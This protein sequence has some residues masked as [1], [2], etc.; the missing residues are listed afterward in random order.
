[1]VD[2]ETASGEPGVR[3]P[4]YGKLR[5]LELPR[6][7]NV[8]GPG[9]VQ[10]NFDSDS[11]ASQV[12]NLLSQQGSQVIKG[13][14]LTLPVGGGLLYVQPVYVQSSSGTQYPLLR[15]VLVSFGDKVGFADTLSEA[16][17]QVFGG[18]SGA[19]TGEDVVDGDAAAANN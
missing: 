2:S 17:D 1:A 3:N 13:N 16:L 9:Q 14:L 15:K 11:T 7:S 18:D 6:S 4:D 19:Q 12:L 8:S 10:N 5:L